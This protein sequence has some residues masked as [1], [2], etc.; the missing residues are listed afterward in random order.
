MDFAV[1]PY[2]LY[3]LSSVRNIFVFYVLNVGKRGCVVRKT[4]KNVGKRGCIFR[5]AGKR[6]VDR[7]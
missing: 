7:M 1:Q 3:F 2:R 6:L 4:G 5:K